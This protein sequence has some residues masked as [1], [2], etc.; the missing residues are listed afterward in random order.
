MTDR[1]AAFLGVGRNDTRVF[2]L[3]PAERAR[4][5]ATAAGLTPVEQAPAQGPISASRGIRRGSRMSATIPGSR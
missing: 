3:A 1:R 5:F 2:G 4:R